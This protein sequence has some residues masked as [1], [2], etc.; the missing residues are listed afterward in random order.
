MEMAAVL[1]ASAQ[2]GLAR[3]EVFY[4]AQA[5]VDS[6][7]RLVWLVLLVSVFCCF[8]G[9]PGNRTSALVVPIVAAHGMLI[10]RTSSRAITSPAG[11]AD[12]MEVRAEVN[13]APDILRDIV[14]HHRGAWRG[15]APPGSPRPTT[16]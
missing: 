5:M 8:G 1:V 2:A 6:G 14:R 11:T 3:D 13:L 4:L 7:D 15:A 16:C 12:T 10:P 9:F